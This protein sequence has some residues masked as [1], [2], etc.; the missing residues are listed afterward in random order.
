MNTQ[1]KLEISNLP[2]LPSTANRQ[3]VII[4]QSADIDFTQVK[5]NESLWGVGIRE[6]STVDPGAP[7]ASIGT[8]ID[9]TPAARA[10]LRY[11]DTLLTINGQPLDTG[12]SGRIDNYNRL[13]G[14]PGTIVEITV[15]Q[16]TQVL[17]LQLPRT[18]LEDYREIEYK[19]IQKTGYVY[20]VPNTNLR[21][22]IYYLKDNYHGREMYFQIR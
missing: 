22:N 9:G 19:V 20:L 15:Q 5:W 12:A 13:R 1:E 16:G 6:I 8:V 17:E 3:P 10:N 21:P 14:L 11:Q 18:S 4:V 2:G 7:G